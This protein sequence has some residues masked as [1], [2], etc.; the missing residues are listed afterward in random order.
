MLYVGMLDVVVGL[1]RGDEGKGRFVDMVAEQYAIIARGNG[2]SNA[3]HTVVPDTMEPLALH[4]IPSGIAYPGKLN[5][6]GNGVYVDPRRLVKEIADVRKAGYTVSPETLLISDAAHLVLPHHIAF[7]ALREGGLKA[8]GSTKSGIAYVAADKYLREGVRLELV[9]TP[10]ILLE[11]AYEGLHE[12][13]KTLPKADRWDDARVKAEAEKW[14]AAVE[15]LKPYL[16]DTVQIIN[17][18]LDAGEKVLAEGAQ[19][20][21]LDINHGMYPSVTSS[22]TTVAGLLDGLGVSPQRLGMVTGVAKSVKSH[23][24]G[25]PFVTEIDDETLSAQIRGTFGQADSEYGKTTLRPRRVG[26]PDLVELRN[27]IRT[28]G[29]DE[30]AL[31]KL[32][33]VPRYGKE[34]KVATSYTYRGDDRLTAPSSALALSE[35]TPNYQTMPTWQSDLSDTRKFEDL[36]EEAAAFIGLFEDEL[37]V[38]ITKIGVGP[39]RSQ[40]IERPVQGRA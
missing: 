28:N 35:C 18:K 16:A 20:Y 15:S 10:K 8:Q 38:P 26:Y 17:E 12:L 27:A 21:W 39:G 19:A 4:Q 30:L 6:I 3:G 25:G 40:V 33:H 23:V 34:I 5:I 9:A 14:L 13:Q 36:P 24:G 31:S 7:D 1:Q 22:S 29:I 2:G 11:R 32:D 37:K